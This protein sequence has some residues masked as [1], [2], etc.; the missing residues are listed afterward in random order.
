MESYRKNTE[1]EHAK[2]ESQQFSIDG[3]FQQPIQYQESQFSTSE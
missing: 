2:E 3:Q 1:E